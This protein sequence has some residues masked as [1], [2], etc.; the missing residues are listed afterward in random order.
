MGLPSATPG[1][2]DAK[3][4]I[5]QKR[6]QNRKQKRQRLPGHARSQGTIGL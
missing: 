3:A 1:V 2:T 4:S 5:C 6:Q